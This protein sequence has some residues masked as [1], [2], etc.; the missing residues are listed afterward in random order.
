MYA[1]TLPPDHLNVAITQIKLGRALLRQNRFKEAEGE[2]LAGYRILSKQAKPS[3]T[4]LQQARK[5]LAEIYKESH[6]P[7]KARQI[8]AEQAAVA[9]TGSKR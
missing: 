7:E 3:V 6:E 8:L 9:P 5:D 2:T 4:W 1:K